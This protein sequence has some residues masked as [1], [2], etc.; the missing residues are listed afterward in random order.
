MTFLSQQLLIQ[1]IGLDADS[2][3]K[4]VKRNAPTTF[5]ANHYNSHQQGTWHPASTDRAGS[6]GS[7]ALVY[8]VSHTGVPTLDT[9]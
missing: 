3:Q 1:D 8:F 6:D 9:V 4:M 5:L 7:P 2:V